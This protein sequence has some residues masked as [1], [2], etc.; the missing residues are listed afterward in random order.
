MQI[1]RVALAACGEG[2]ESREFVPVYCGADYCDERVCLCI[3]EHI[4]ETKGH[5]FTKFSAHVACGRGSFT[6]W[7]RCNTLCCDHVMFSCNGPYAGVTLPQQLRCNVVHANTPAVWYWLRVQFCPR[8]RQVPKLSESFVQEVPGRS[9]PH[10]I[11]FLHGC[12][13]SREGRG[14][15]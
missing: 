12:L 7:R 14:G 2:S 11:A 13:M 1:P 9:M 10:T 5:N 15:P 6:L 3:H 8:Q 4:S